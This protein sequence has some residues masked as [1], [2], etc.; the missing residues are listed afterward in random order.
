MITHQDR[1]FITTILD[2][3][4]NESRKLIQILGPEFQNSYFYYFFGVPGQC[5]LSDDV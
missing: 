2:N 1:G 4:N 5:N 3:E